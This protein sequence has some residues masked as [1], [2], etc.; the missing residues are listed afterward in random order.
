MGWI[1]EA[2][3]DWFWLGFVERRSKGKPRWVWAF[4]AVS[5]LIAVGVPLA[6]LWL[7]FR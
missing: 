6:A 1:L 7:L 2:A 3:I 4:W 5:P